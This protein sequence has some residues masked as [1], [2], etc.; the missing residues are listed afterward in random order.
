MSYNPDEAISLEELA[1]LL[2]LHGLGEEDGH[3]VPYPSAEYVRENYNNEENKLF[4]QTFENF[5][6][7]YLKRDYTRELLFHWYLQGLAVFDPVALN[8]EERT[9]P[10]K[11]LDDRD[12]AADFKK[13]SV[14]LGD[15]KKFLKSNIYAVPAGL[16]F[17]ESSESAAIAKQS[18]TTPDMHLMLEA[19]KRFWENADPKDRD[20]YPN[21]NDIVEWLCRKGM[22]KSRATWADKII[23][24][25]WA[26]K[27]GRRS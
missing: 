17:A 25:K 5:R 6:N 27:G 16:P 13:L 2:L 9:P 14:K 3:Q 19:S 18:Y 22:D 11:N 10:M 20:T 12:P 26:R 24:P 7:H 8:S 15:L 21:S 1:H 23:R 4:I